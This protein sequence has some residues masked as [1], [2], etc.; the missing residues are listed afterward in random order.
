MDYF[1]DC[2]GTN[3]TIGFRD[4]DEGG[5]GVQGRAGGSVAA[6]VCHERFDESKKPWRLARKAKEWNGPARELRS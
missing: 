5:K 1:G 3:R 4:R 6:N 2:N